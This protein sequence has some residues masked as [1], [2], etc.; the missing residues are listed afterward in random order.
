MSAE[1]LKKYSRLY[2][3][4]DILK[5]VQPDTHAS[6]YLLSGED[7][8]G[9]NV[10]ARLV[11]ARI[12]G[13][14]AS[15]AFD[16]F[17]D[18]AVYPH[19]EPKQTKAAKSKK[20]ETVKRVAVSVEDIREIVG[21]LYLTPFELK[22]RIYIIE[23]AESMSEICQNKLLKS[24][25]EPP[26]S[27]CFILCAS[28]ALLPT[29][30][31]RCNRIELP[32][33]PVSVLERELGAFHSDVSA[34][35]LAAR[36]SRGNLGMAER[37]LADK[38]FRAVYDSAISI[39][40]RANGSRMFGAEAAI[41]DK[42]TREKA[43]SVLGVME[44]LLCDVARLAVGA[45][46]VFDERDV[47]RCAAGFTP[48]AAAVCAEHVRVARRRTDGNCMPIAVLDTTILKIMEEK[49]LCRRS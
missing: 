33:F 3:E 44:Y 26:R 1:L 31:S 16:D 13:L 35:A 2:E 37:I 27:V 12:L 21:S 32:P 6:A 22:K 4:L 48:Y 17:A 7:G 41:Y 29:V 10:F 5:A 23:S 11:A 24:L 19:A 39:L 20:A 18:I 40:E 28:G 47:R 43:S 36:A 45:P 42:F 15:R 38:D 49:A 30:E 8:E 34:V 25:E 9:L 46:T 14:P